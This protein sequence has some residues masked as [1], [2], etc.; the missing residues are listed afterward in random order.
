MT[1][2]NTISLLEAFVVVIGLIPFMVYLLMMKFYLRD[3]QVIIAEKQNGVDRRNVMG[4][5]RNASL[6]AFIVVVFIG[7]GLRGMTV[8]EPIRES[9]RQQS[10][11]ILWALLSIEIVAAGA[12]LWDYV[13]RRKNMRDLARRIAL[14]KR[15]HDDVYDDE[16]QVSERRARRQERRGEAEYQG[17]E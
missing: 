7:L 6:W 16:Q 12:I 2:T 1:L 4:N 14:H 9:T 17:N 5:I 8:P 3:R 15:R 11:L 10:A 13:D